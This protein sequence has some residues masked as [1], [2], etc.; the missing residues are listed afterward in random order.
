MSL[1]GTA[2]DA[3]GFDSQIPSDSN[4]QAKDKNCSRTQV[5]LGVSSSFASF[6]SLPSRDR[7]ISRNWRFIAQDHFGGVRHHPPT[8]TRPAKPEPVLRDVA[9]GPAASSRPSCLGTGG[10]GIEFHPQSIVG[11]FEP[12][13]FRAQAVDAI[14]R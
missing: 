10:S 6:V 3:P 8:K 4:A 2:G 7:D 11:D 1:A 12:D 13:D 5:T 14:G 9:C